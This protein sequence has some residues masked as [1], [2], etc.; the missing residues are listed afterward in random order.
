MVSMNAHQA[1]QQSYL[2][3]IEF[4]GSLSAHTNIVQD[5][6]VINAVIDWSRS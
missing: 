6:R 3:P 1:G 5:D 2:R 4:G